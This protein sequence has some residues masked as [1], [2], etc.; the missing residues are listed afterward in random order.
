MS[1]SVAAPEAPS[2]QPAAPSRAR[3]PSRWP[4]AVLIVAMAAAALLLLH[5][6]RGFTFYYDEWNFLIN[7]QEFSADS[8]LRPHNEHNVLVVVLLFQGLWEVVGLGHYS[9]FLLLVVVLH[10]LCGG[11]L[12]AYARRRVGAVAALAPAVV[13]LFLGTAWEIILWPFEV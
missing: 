3:L 7:R 13:V 6:T 2:P 8:L 4:A 10:L 5:L 9:A 12:Y 11:M 1:S